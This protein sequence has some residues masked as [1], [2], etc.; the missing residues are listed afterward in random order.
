[1]ADKKYTYRVKPGYLHGAYNQHGPGSLVELT[2]DEA[3]GFL[4]KLELV[5]KADLVEPVSDKGQATHL[6]TM[7]VAQLKNLLEYQELENPKPTKK[8]DIV[9]AILQA[10]GIEAE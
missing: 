8:D 7:T 6:A 10:R 4:D 5:G 1:M 3:S 2:E 9:A